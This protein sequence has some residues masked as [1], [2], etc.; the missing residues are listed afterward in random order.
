MRLYGKKILGKKVNRRISDKKE[1]F[2]AIVFNVYPADR[3]AA[4]KIQGSEEQ[5]RARY[6]ENWEKT[7]VWLKKG[8]AVRI[9]RTGGNR[10]R[11]ELSGHG[12]YIPTGLST[13]PPNVGEIPDTII[14]GLET[15]ATIPETMSV[16]VTDGSFLFGEDVYYLSGTT[17]DSPGFIMGAT[18][19]FMGTSKQMVE[20][21]AA[22][23]TLYRMDII[24]IGTDGVLQYV[25]G[26]TYSSNPQP[27]PTPA[28]KF[29]ICTI[30][31]PPSATKIYQDYINTAW[32][33]ERAAYMEITA[34]S[35][36]YGNPDSLRI[37][38]SPGD[39][40]IGLVYLYL[41]QRLEFWMITTL[42]IYNQYRRPFVSNHKIDVKYIQ[43][44][45][46][47][48]DISG[49]NSPISS[50]A[51][52]RITLTNASQ[53]TF[54][55]MGGSHSAVIQYEYIHEESSIMT[56]QN[57]WYYDCDSKLLL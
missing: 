3:Y 30:I 40:C 50:T 35:E 9:T 46:S 14:E 25:K 52:G 22:H 26:S 55:A 54:K 33:P 12:Y 6:P 21:D 17:M 11:I 2:D 56:T 7:P 28:G 23:A 13:F 31:I 4:I 41:D 5:I 19:T 38:H 57:I 42:K 27:P 18:A 8:N 29:R 39:R 43:G 48:I 36:Y 53:V 16:Q 45:G 20:I 15:I 1:T 24:V 32:E 47:L 10:S 37:F 49:G 34:Y 51:V 44:N